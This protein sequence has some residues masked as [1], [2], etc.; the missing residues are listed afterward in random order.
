MCKLYA[1]GVSTRT[2]GLRGSRARPRAH[3]YFMRN[4]GYGFNYTAVTSVVHARGVTRGVRGVRGVPRQHITSPTLHAV[5]CCI[6]HVLQLCRTVWGEIARAGRRG[7]P[8]RG[9][10]RALLEVKTNRTPASVAS[11]R[12]TDKAFICW[13]VQVN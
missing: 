13:A 1:G 8:L 7:G 6:V 4:R 9:P 10:V 5:P 12:Y 2:P 11:R 3:T